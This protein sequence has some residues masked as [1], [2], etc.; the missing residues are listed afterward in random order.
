MSALAQ[1]APA[2]D[3]N[4]IMTVADFKATGLQKLSPEEIKALNGWLTQFA[5][6]VHNASSASSATPPPTPSVV[7]SNIEG[8]FEGWTGDSIFKLDNGQIW[9]QTSY[10]YTYHYAYRP[11]VT[12]VKVGALYKMKVDNVSTT[13]NV[14]RLK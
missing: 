13:I 6:R 2:I 10:S 8:E 9:Q 11:R 5:L 12:I 4:Q 3:I 1:E 7:E 14:R